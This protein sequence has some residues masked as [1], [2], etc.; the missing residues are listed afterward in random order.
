MFRPELRIV[1]QIVDLLLGDN[2]VGIVDV[3]VRTGQGY[4]LGAQLSRLLADAPA[5]VAE[6]GSRDGLALDVLA[7][8]LEHVLQIIHSAVAGGLRT[9]QRAAVGEALAGQNAVF[10]HA[11]QAA[12]L[13]VQIADL[14]A[15]HAHVAGGNVDVGP[16]VAIQR[17]HERLA[18]THDLCIGLAGGI[19]VRT[20]LGA[21]DGQAGQAVLENLLKAQE[22]DDAGIHV[23]LEPQAALV[24]ADRTVELAAIADV[25][26]ANFRC[27]LPTPHGR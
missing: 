10:K 18:E 2:A 4:D 3:S 11:L 19:K 21:A 7:E 8:V 5:H 1:Q 9:D 12:I 23:G 22:L 26:C 6:A 13:T 25:R 17:L 24:G 16:D 15:A 20:A 27:H 14:T